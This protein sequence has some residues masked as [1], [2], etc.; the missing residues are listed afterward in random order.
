LVFRHWHII[1]L[2]RPTLELIEFKV[3]C[4]VFCTAESQTIA[5]RRVSVR[6]KP[7]PQPIMKRIATAG[8]RFPGA[9]EID[10]CTSCV[11]IST[12][13]SLRTIYNNN[14]VRTGACCPT[15]AM[16]NRDYYYY[17]Y[18]CVVQWCVFWHRECVH[19]ATEN[20]VGSNMMRTRVNI[21]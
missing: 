17:Y 19:L 16:P 13:L 5:I 7:R 6:L 14:K 21:P 12:Q 15:P 10:V 8:S 11:L 18:H 4:T 9:I 2:E 20:R 1:I 3:L